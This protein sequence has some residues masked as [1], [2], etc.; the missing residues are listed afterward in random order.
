MTV[1]AFCSRQ[2]DC[3]QFI[4]THGELHACKSAEGLMAAMNIRSNPEEWQLFKNSSMHNLKAVLLHKGNILPSIPVACAVHMK[5]TY[6]DM[7]EILSF[8]N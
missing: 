3:E 4:I 5:T 8:V 2:K 1:R 6:E 7:K